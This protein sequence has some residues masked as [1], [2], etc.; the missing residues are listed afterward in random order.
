MNIL[1]TGSA[2]QLGRDL[3]PVLTRMGAVTCV[4]R[5][6]SADGG[7]VLQRDLGDLDGLEALLDGLRPDVIVNAAAYTAVDRAEA[8]AE[9]AYR[10]NEELPDCLA[11]WSAG[12][13]CLLVHYSTDYVFSGDA[14][15]A[16]RETDP[17]GPLSIYGKS[18]LDGE[19]A[20]AASGCRHAVLRTSWLYSRH[21]NNFVLTMLRLARER[22]TLSIVSDQVG[23]PTWA[24]NLA[25]VTGTV[26]A[27]L[28]SAESGSRSRGTWHYCDSGVVSWY[29]FAQVI[30]DTAFEVGLLEKAP[31]TL[32]VSSAD[33]PQAAVRPPYSVLDT[34]AIGR[35]LGVEPAALRASVKTCLEELKQ[36]GNF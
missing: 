6:A 30:F 34:S 12:H 31:Q 7:E 33:Y 8:D 9:A 1:L 23:C 21:G 20:I 25:G 28:T 13:D 24:R 2:G 5:D 19:R 14:S 4:D 15:R 35:D 17:T 3:L 18:K 27:R 10:V 22:S 26:I 16:Y 29:D 36:H 11:R 32:A